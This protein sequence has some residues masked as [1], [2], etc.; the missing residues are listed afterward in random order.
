MRNSTVR[1]LHDQAGE[2]ESEYFECDNPK[3]VII[4]SHG[5]GVRRWDGEHFF[6]NIAKHYVDRAVYLVDQNQVIKDGCQLNDI[7]IM[8][9]R[10]QKLIDVAM[11]NYPGVPIVVLAHSMGCGVSA[12]LELDDVEKVIFVTPGAGNEFMKLK[13]RY[14]EDIIN[15]G[16]MVKTTDGLNKLISK[17]YL[18]SVSKITWENEYSKLLKKFQ[19]VYVFE[20]GDEEIVGDDRFK[21][22]DM[23]FKSYQI[24]PG[25]THNLHGKALK[26]FFVEL[27]YLV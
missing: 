7:N 17:D 12:Q 22:R 16:G 5:N 23:P 21:H 3:S 10:V 18:E 9:E 15:G 26:L 27:E 4:C 24:I 6:L 14:G 20:A 2:Y 8:S 19:N 11:N 13:K 25:A 1:K